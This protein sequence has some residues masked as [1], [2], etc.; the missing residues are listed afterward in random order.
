MST[1]IK[2]GQVWAWQD[3]YDAKGPHGSTFEIIEAGTDVTYRY[4]DTAGFDPEVPRAASAE[5]VRA[6]ANLVRCVCRAGTEDTCNQHSATPAPLD[7]SKVKAGDTVTVTV[8]AENP[9]FRD[10]FITGEVYNPGGTGLYVGGWPVREHPSVTLTAH[11]PA[12]KPEWQPRTTGVAIVRGVPRRHVIRLAPNTQDGEGGYAW[13]SVDLIDGPRREINGYDGTF[14]HTEGDVI[15]FL[16][17]SPTTTLKVTKGRDAGGDGRRARP[18]LRRLHGYRRRRPEHQRELPV[19]RALHPRHPGRW[20]VMNTAIDFHRPEPEAQ[21]YVDEVPKDGLVI[22]DHGDIHDAR[23]LPE[24]FTVCF[25][26]NG[27]HRDGQADRWGMH[28][29]QA[30]ADREAHITGGHILAREL[31]SVTRVVQR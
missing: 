21:A 18:A 7:P 26:S 30:A 5:V 4:L 10:F 24:Q 2:P 14:L 22:V 17:D 19:R 23:R 25:C 8:K 13:A 1:D 16:P 15:D 31:F 27:Q 6:N 20:G 3:T 12:P 9:E 28:A 11:Q 29:G